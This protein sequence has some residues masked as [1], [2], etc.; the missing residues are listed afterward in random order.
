MRE[1]KRKIFTY[2]RPLFGEAELFI[3]DCTF[4]SGESPLK[5]CRDLEVSN[6]NFKWKY[7]LWYCK[8]VR[9]A[10]GALFEGARAGIWY[11]ENI[12]FKDT[13]IDAPKCFRRAKNIS[14]T[15][16]AFTNAQETLW[17]CDGV[18]MK[19]VTARG[20][21]FMM[22]SSNA[23]IDGLTLDGNY[24]FDG[25]KNAVLRNAKLITKDAFWNCENMTVYDSY[26]SG[27]YL[28]W[29]SKNLTLI[30]CT[31]ESLQGMCYID[32]LKLVNCKLINTNLAFEYSTVD[33]DVASGIDSV[34]NPSG[35]VIK[36][37]SIGDLIIESDKVSPEN[38]KIICADIKR[39]SSHPDWEVEL[40]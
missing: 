7:P 3:R 12:E 33:A 40:R 35:G 10:G 30:N 8:S 2:E 5:E 22:N 11:S 9:V 38:T 17:S 18:K 19:N 13:Q 39:R 24:S 25:V 28:G 15:N 23:E 20:D 16:V 27:E 36:A 29:N 4:E 37:E 1:I 21:Y 32:N 31:V 26:I 14:F 34:Y 6:S